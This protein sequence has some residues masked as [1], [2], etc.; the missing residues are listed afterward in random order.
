MAEIITSA[1]D[2]PKLTVSQ[3]VEDPT[4]IPQR[5]LD[6]L[7]HQFLEDLFFRQGEDN[8]GVVAFREAAGAY[9]ADDAEE[10][11]E[12]GEIPVSSPELGALKSAYGI[13]TGEAIRISYEMVHENKI[14]QVETHIKALQKTVIRTGVRA[15]FAALNAAKVPELQVSAPWTGGEPDKDLL[16]AIE[17]VQSATYGDNPDRQYEDD[18][19]TILLHPSSYT[20]LIRNEKMQRYYIGNAAADNPIFKAADG[21][22][23]FGG[24]RDIELFGMLRVATSR[25][26]PQG[27]AYVFEQGAPGFKSDTMPLTA[28][29][30]YSEGGESSLGGPT[31]SWRSDVVRKRAIAVDNPRSVVKLTGIA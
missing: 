16:D 26:I 10:I 28:T 7:Q 18:P 6:G 12:F 24:L 8:K 2:G 1:F 19:N 27:A 29:S 15:T 4:F 14:D 5:V 3:M 13:K 25:M 31:M 22:A 21:N 30:L 17:L 11:A 20:K 23:L 9:L